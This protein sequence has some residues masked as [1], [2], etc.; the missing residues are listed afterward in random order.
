MTP[1][2]PHPGQLQG[3]PKLH[4]SGA[5]LRAIVSGRGHATEKIAEVAEEQLRPHVESLE[6]YVK[7]TN[8]FLLKLQSSPQPIVDQHGYVPLLFCMDVKKL[9]PSV[10]RGD[11][12]AACRLAL[13]NRRDASLPTEE[14]IQMIE[15]V[16]DNNNFN[17]TADNQFVQTDGTAIGSRLG[18]NYACTYLGWWEKQLLDGAGFKPLMYFRY[19]DDIF[20]VWLHGEQELNNFQN[21][22]NQINPKIQV[23]LRISTSEI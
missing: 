3:N 4:K 5:P 13:D 7:D 11:G 12:I 15:L 1:A 23:D 16:L 18:K 21:R 19:I 6:S 20:G 2:R 17:L 8:D 22:A 10:P 14:V 9:S